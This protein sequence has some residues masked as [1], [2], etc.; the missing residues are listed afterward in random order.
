MIVLVLLPFFFLAYRNS[1]RAGQKGRSS[2]GWF[3][4]TLLMEFVGYIM[5][6]LLLML[7]FMKNTNAQL[8]SN[9]YD[10]NAIQDLQY[11]YIDYVLA[12]NFN[13]ITILVFTIGGY[14]LV[15]Y[16]ISKASSITK[17]DI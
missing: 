13:G 15:R 1:I 14:V 16:W 3:V 6:A 2:L 17:I 9:P 7:M 10:E 5:G 4:L 12:S 11:K 8:P